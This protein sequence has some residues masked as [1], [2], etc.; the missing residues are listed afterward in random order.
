MMIDK[1]SSM[2]KHDLYLYPLIFPDAYDLYPIHEDGSN[3][4]SNVVIDS[5]DDYIRSEQC[6][7]EYML[8]GDE[9]P[10]WQAIDNHACKGASVSQAFAEKWMP[11]SQPLPL[12]CPLKVVSAI[13]IK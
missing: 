6:S 11:L 5:S 1:F 8:S 10:L 3:I 2:C 7:D 9:K 4:V 12:G 13:A